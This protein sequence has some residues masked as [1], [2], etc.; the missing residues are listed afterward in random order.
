MSF[1]RRVNTLHLTRFCLGLSLFLLPLMVR[2][3][4]GPEHSQITSE[5]IRLLPAEHA[6]LLAPE[7]SAL[8]HIY[9]EF[10]DQNWPAYGQWGDGNAEPY[11]PRFA[12]TRREWDISYYCG[13]NPI[14]REGTSYPHSAPR[15]YEAV[16]AYFLRVAESWQAGRF[17]EGVRILG[18]A[19]HYVEDS[20]AFGHLQ[21]VHRS[22]HWDAR[23]PLNAGQYEPRRLGDTP[24]AAAKEIVA[25]M[26]EMVDTTEKAMDAVLAKVA[27]PLAEVKRLSI[28]DPVPKEAQRAMILARHEFPAEMDAAT[29]ACATAAAHVC[30][31]MVYTALCFAPR[32]FPAPKPNA[33]G[34]NLVFNPSFEDAGDENA[35]GWCLGWLDLNDKQG[36]AEWYRAGTHWDKPVKAGARSAMVL[37]APERG[38]EWRQTWRR[39]TRVQPGETYRASAWV[40]SR[41]EQGG[42]SLALEIADNEYHTLARPV[43]VRVEGRGEWTEMKVEMVVPDRARWLRVV[44][45]SNA[46]GAAWFDEARLERV[47][48]SN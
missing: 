44:L 7:V 41:T 2:G 47:E 3:W 45:H 18:A 33:A 28:G 13:W 16:P 5:A 1:I 39:A 42:S 43:S 11:L 23:Q 38:I 24:E 32:T 14:T 19:M 26:K 10:P 22:L 40:K 20:A 34:V 31:D 6:A 21:A 46:S 29:R 12:D 17:E 36:R 9:C 37:W 30:A 27:M 35:E 4:G 8:T 48:V 15:A 25:R